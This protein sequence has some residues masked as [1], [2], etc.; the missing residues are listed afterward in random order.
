MTDSVLEHQEGSTAARTNDTLWYWAVVLA[1]VVGIALRLRQ[2]AVSRSLWVDEAALALNIVNRTFAELLQPLDYLQGAPIGY[3]W[4]ARL[5]VE[6]LGN[7]ESSLRLASLLASMAALALFV[8]VARRYLSWPATALAA[9]IIALSERLIYYASEVKQ[10]S[11]DV[12]A[13]VIGLGIFWLLYQ[14]SSSV[15]RVLVA[16]VAGVVSVWLSHAAVFV[17][18]G[19]TIALLADARQQRSRRRAILVAALGAVWLLPFLIQYALSIGALG[20]NARLLSF[21][22]GG[23]PPRSAAV[24]DLVD[25]LWIKTQEPF[26][27]NLGLP[28]AGLA[29]L[30]AATGSVSLFRRDRVLL[31]SLLA[32]LLLVLI[33]AFLR[34]YPFADRLILFTAP[35]LIIVLAEGAQ[36]LF[37][38]LARLW[39]PLGYAFLVILLASPALRAVELAAEP[40]FNEEIV[41]VLRYIEDSWQE[42]DHIYLYYSSFLPFKYYQS[43][44]GFADDDYIWGIES[45]DTWQPYFEE[46]EALARGS[47]RVW[48]LFSHVYTESG[49][50]EEALLINYLNQLGTAPLDIYQAPGASAYLYDFGVP[51]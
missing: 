29:L 47:G 7:S 1:V 40:Q 10:Y 21:W 49:A 31:L 41:P 3:L 43:R 22:A 45:R 4:A 37:V 26:R 33:A 46:M 38:M 9:L 51:N 36:A 50:S 5:F 30:C 48:L 28:L 19:I 18:G 39:R 13:A 20:S 6:L 11:F 23:F 12:L 17:L 35:L 16:A 44:F 34:R 15:W 27:L 2:F 42:G 14:R 8:P 24:L 25:W 32:P